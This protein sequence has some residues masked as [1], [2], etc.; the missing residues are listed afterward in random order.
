[1]TQKNKQ[2]GNDILLLY[3]IIHDGTINEEENL[4]GLQKKKRA[5]KTLP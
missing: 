4:N 5:C 2:H 3:I 1:M